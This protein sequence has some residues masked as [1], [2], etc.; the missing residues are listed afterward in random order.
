MSVRDCLNY[1]EIGNS[2]LYLNQIKRKS[3]LSSGVHLSLLS[4]YHLKFL[5][6][7]FLTMTDYSLEL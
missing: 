1:V 7:D 4:D 6:S 3:Q 5:L 2:S